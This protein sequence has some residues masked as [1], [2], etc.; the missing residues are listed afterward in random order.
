M[1]CRKNAP[2]SKECYARNGNYRFPS[3]LESHTKNLNA[4][5]ESPKNYFNT[6][7]KYLKRRSHIEYFRY[8][9]SGDIVDEK[10]LKGM[11][12][13]AKE[14]PN[15][16]FLAFTKKFELV[17]GYLKK[18]YRIPKNL[19]ILFSN[20][21]KNFIVDNPYNL[22][23]TYVD[24]KD[25]SKNPTLPTKNAKVCPGSCETCKMCW[26]LK[27]KHAVIFNQH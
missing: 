22:P 16:K 17:N 12:S 8:H 9:S 24:F 11:V 18:G 4:Y 26:N 25:K 13:V 20:W 7:S 6:I 3:V 27:K 21:D 5:L 15:I 2:C 19:K 10:Y 1:T 14:F 23:M